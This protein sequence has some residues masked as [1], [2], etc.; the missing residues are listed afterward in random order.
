MYT[1][2]MKPH[3]STA[4]LHVRRAWTLYKD[5]N[6]SKHKDKTSM[7]TSLLVAATERLVEDA[8]AS[9]MA[10]AAFDGL[11]MLYTSPVSSPHELR[12]CNTV[13]RCQVDLLSKFHK[14]WS[15]L[16]KSFS[17]PH[18][19]FSLAA[20]T[21]GNRV[22]A[23]GAKFIDEL[24]TCV[25]LGRRPEPSLVQ[26]SYSLVLP[27]LLLLVRAGDLFSPLH[28][29]PPSFTNTFTNITHHSQLVDFLISVGRKLVLIFIEIK[30][31]DAKNTKMKDH[32]VVHKKAAMNK[33]LTQYFDFLVRYLSVEDDSG[34]DILAR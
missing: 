6:R 9:D 29:F 32:Q 30:V 13:V 20:E 27:L 2:L 14:S 28:S 18:A 19:I 25:E 4:E 17:E 12:V 8:S 1:Y 34:E 15:P 24:T 16:R 23:H 10:R 33:L 31:E 22:L 21:L 11:S 5:I 7:L 26:V 3:D